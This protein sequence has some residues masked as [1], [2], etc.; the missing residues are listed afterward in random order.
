VSRQPRAALQALRSRT[1]FSSGLR[2]ELCYALSLLLSSGPELHPAWQRAARA[3]LPERLVRLAGGILRSSFLWVLLP[4]ALATKP[5]ES[6]FTSLVADLRAISP[7]DLQRELI[8]GTFH[9]PRIVD[10]ILRL[11]TSIPDALGLATP[12]KREWLAYTGLY[13]YDRDHPTAVALDQL[14][15]QPEAFLETVATV[16]ETFWSANFRTTW[17]ALQPEYAASI[18]VHRRRYGELPLQGFFDSAHVRIVVDEARQ[19]LQ[20]LR[21][22]YAIAASDIHELVLIPSAFN[23]ELMWSVLENDGLTRV[24]CPY[25]DRSI[26]V[27]GGPRPSDAGPRPDPALLLRALGDTTRYALVTLLARE[28]YTAAELARALA[29]SKPT[30]SHHMA[31]LREA[32]LIEE[33]TIPGGVRLV[34]RRSVLESMSDLVVRSLYSDAPLP[35]LKRSRQPL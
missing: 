23:Q 5:L 35:A 13:P 31:L 17:S 22:N 7:R 14:L 15:R 24:Y 25:L 18:R 20:A 8:R 27:M 1:T 3:A 30:I 4:D 33:L 2:F 21:G 6:S 10:A 9:E 28:S 34:L 32:G 19:R 16:L 12:G 29:V 26:T 11:G